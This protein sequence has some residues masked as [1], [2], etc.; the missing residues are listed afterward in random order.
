MVLLPETGKCAIFSL[1]RIAI[2]LI[3]YRWLDSVVES[4]VEDVR[5][6]IKLKILKLLF[7]VVHKLLYQAII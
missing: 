5:I 1:Q 4:P 3:V 7:Q 2:L 6:L